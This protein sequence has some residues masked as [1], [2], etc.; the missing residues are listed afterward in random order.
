LFQQALDELRHCL[1]CLTAENS[2]DLIDETRQLILKL[3]QSNEAIPRQRTELGLALASLVDTRPGVGVTTTTA[4]RALPDI[5]WINVP[6]G[7]FLFG[8]DP[9]ADPV[10]KDIETPQQRLELPSYSLSRYPITYRQYEAF[11]DSDGYTNPAYWSERG[12]Q[13]K[14]DKTCPTLAWEDSY[15]RVANQPVIG[16]S[17]YEMQAF[18]QWFSTQVG[19]EIRLPT[20][21][22]WEKAAR[23]PEGLIYPY[24][25]TFDASKG[26]TEPSGIGRP[27]A[28]GLF[29]H[30]ASPY[31]VLDMSGNIFEWTTTRFRPYPYDPDD[32]REDLT[33][34][35]SRIFRGGAFA[36][37]SVL[38]RCA[39]RSHFY[40]YARYDWVGFRV[41]TSTLPTEDP[42]SRAANRQQD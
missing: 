15:F 12:W 1:A 37:D 42:G 14:A 7:A 19:N 21:P 3:L 34:Y 18:C 25:N 36:Y 9:T 30:G 40:P 10:A 38:A 16:V 8:S 28:V 20:E 6:A 17:W 33:Q 23:G 27:C 35:G 39:F 41:C 29:P 22:E 13:W 26:N 5:E 24:G 2:P 31:G 4:G 11:V 32:G